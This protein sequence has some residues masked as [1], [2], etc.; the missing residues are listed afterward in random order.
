[1]SSSPLKLFFVFS[2]RIARRSIVW[3]ASGRLR[4][5][6]CPSSGGASP[7]CTR[8]E[9]LS[10]KTKD[11]KSMAGSLSVSVPAWLP[12]GP[13]ASEPPLFACLGKFTFPSIRAS[14]EV[15]RIPERGCS[16][17]GF[18]LQT[19]QRRLRNLHGLGIRADVG[20]ILQVL[21]E[22]LLVQD[23]LSKIALANA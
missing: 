11:A 18:V 22:V 13:P 6:L 12:P 9:W 10:D 14:L 23:S 15:R 7:R 16:A 21:L 19:L 5:C 20:Q 17:F 1:R 2:W 3:R 8:A 4:S